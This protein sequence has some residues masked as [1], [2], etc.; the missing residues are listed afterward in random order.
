MKQEERQV[1]SSLRDKTKDD[2]NEC[3]DLTSNQ[4]KKKSRVA[5]MS[6]ERERTKTDQKARK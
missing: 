1:E 3:L 2:N 6:R 5:Y 4:K